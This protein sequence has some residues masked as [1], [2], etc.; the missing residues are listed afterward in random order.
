MLRLQNPDANTLAPLISER[1]LGGVANALG[2]VVYLDGSLPPSIT[3]IVR[4][5]ADPIEMVS[6][7][8]ETTNELAATVLLENEILLSTRTLYFDASNW[9][10]GVTVVATSVDDLD[11]V[12]GL[13]S[14]LFEVSTSSAELYRNARYGYIQASTTLVFKRY[15]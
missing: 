14:V 5:S 9:S 7:T 2:P 6:L 13:V 10:T 4:L 12:S 11:A 3:F 1:D 8:L 15:R